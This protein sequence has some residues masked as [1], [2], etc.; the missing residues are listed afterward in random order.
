[1]HNKAQLGDTVVLIVTT[2][3]VAALLVI[4]F[5]IIKS[6]TIGKSAAE[7][8]TISL[9]EQSLI[10][11][12]A[13]IDTPVSAN[14]QEI[15]MADLIRLARINPSYENDVRMQ[16]ENI[17]NKIYSKWGFSTS[18]GLSAGGVVASQDAASSIDIQSSQGKITVFLGVSE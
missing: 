17:F 14:G 11:L 6:V 5:F 18:S 16:T 4:F 2:I 8:D 10:S 15:K 12:K 9:K 7:A 1:M 13:Y 3:V